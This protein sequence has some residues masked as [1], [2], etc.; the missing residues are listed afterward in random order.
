MLFVLTLV[1]LSSYQVNGIPAFACNFENEN[2][3]QMQNGVW[4]NPELPLYNFTIVT[5]E[6]V[7]NK[8]L[9][10]SIDHTYN[11]SFGHFFYW[12]RPSNAAHTSMDGLVSIPTFEQR[13][14]MCLNFAYYIK[15]SQSINN[16]SFLGVHIK[17]CYQTTL[18]VVRTDDTDGWK[19]DQVQL[20]DLTCNVTIWFDVWPSISS[21]V[22]VALDDLLIDICPRYITTTASISAGYSLRST[23][24]VFLQIILLF[25]AI[26][27]V[28]C[29]R[30]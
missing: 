2:S 9:A 8:E 13:D 20:L 30:F 21:A 6:T 18:W 5:G 15:S 29:N 22:S 24:D 3:C 4:F 12:Y 26:V 7:L 1:L 25:I 17:G 11:S 27:T 28:R 23:N 14:H 19:T 16:E 10:P